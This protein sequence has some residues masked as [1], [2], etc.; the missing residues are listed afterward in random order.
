M[1]NIPQW[2]IDTFNEF[3]TGTQE[4]CQFDDDRGPTEIV[5]DE[6]EREFNAIFED[7]E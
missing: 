2:I 7:R 4:S 1:K 3:E 6:I 5:G